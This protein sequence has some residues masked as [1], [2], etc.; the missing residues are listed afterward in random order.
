MMV[1]PMSRRRMTTPNASP[2]DP[3]PEVDPEAFLAALLH[4]SE[5]DAAEVRE[6]AT[7]KADAPT[8]H[9]VTAQRWAEGWELHIAGV[10]VTQTRTLATAERQVRDYLATVLDA[11]ASNAVI[12]V[13]EQADE[14]ADP[15]GQ[16]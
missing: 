7:E 5:E 6:Q 9:A 4:L 2:P 3:T 1:A 8:R 15:R 10:G 13:R 12:E 16:R 14:R 11:D